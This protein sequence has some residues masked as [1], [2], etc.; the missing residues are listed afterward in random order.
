MKKILPYFRTRTANKIKYQIMKTNN[1]NL[2]IDATV[3]SGDNDNSITINLDL[4]DESLQVLADGLGI[5][6]EDLTDEML[7]QFFLEAFKDVLSA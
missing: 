1:D 6:V 7:Q 5:T 3:T 4:S 2:K